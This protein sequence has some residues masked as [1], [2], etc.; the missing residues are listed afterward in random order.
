MSRM[1][2]SCSPAPVGGTMLCTVSPVAHPLP[3]LRGFSPGEVSLCP[4]YMVTSYGHSMV[5]TPSF[6]PREQ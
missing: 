4:L 5:Q 3:R 1:G 2:D 6:L